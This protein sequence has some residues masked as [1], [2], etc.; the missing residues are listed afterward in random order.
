MF[1]K[2]WNVYSVF[3]GDYEAITAF[4]RNIWL[5]FVSQVIGYKYVFWA[6]EKDLIFDKL[7]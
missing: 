5:C 2:G 3:D 1:K 7:F 4:F 6:L